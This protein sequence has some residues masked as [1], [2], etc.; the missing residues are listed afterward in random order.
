MDRL[1][2]HAGRTPDKIAVQMAQSQAGR[3]YAQ[4]D[5]D[6]DRLCRDLQA[7]GLVEGQTIAL[8]LANH[9]RALECWWGARRA[10]LYYVPLS[11]K[12]TAQEIAYILANCD[13]Q[14]IIAD[15]ANA[16]LARRSAGLHAVNVGIAIVEPASDVEMFLPTSARE[17]AAYV[18]RPSL[19]GRE[20][21]YS[22]G[23][24]GRPKGI[25]RPLV[26]VD[27]ASELPALEQRM[28]QLFEIDNTTIYLS[29]SPLYHATGRFLNRVVEEGGTAVILPKFDAEAA[30][31]AIE[32]HKVTNT[33]WV[34]TMFSRLLALSTE[35]R[36]R[37][38]LSSHKIALHA[39]APCPLAVKY[40]MIK[41][42][43]PIVHEYYGGSENAGV[44][45]IRAEDWLARPGSVGKSI[46][47][48]LHILDND[49]GELPVGEL[50]LISFDGGVPFTYL[51]AEEAVGPA[52]IRHATYGD[53]GWVDCD[54]YL[55]VSD[56]R[57]DLIISGGVNVYPKEV[58]DVLA[59]HSAVEEVAVIGISD[60]EFGQRVEAVIKLKKDMCADTESII[61][62]CCDKLSSIKCPRSVNFVE[63]LPR[64]ENGKILKRV[65]RE[66]Y[67]R[68]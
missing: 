29:V 9:C 36:A 2:Q 22:S 31:H 24:T 15:P 35:A 28:R 46:S 26:T 4:L 14:L 17:L 20:L 44:T 47:G 23:T 13:A 25:K 50:G 63:E 58:E 45:F 32:R 40:E 56:R 39:A 67:D 7:L 10:G 6:A 30:L 43:G 53:L 68:S 34:P 66:L 27:K 11:T 51:G 57:N 55:F 61:E 1:S 33:Q 59:E 3:T 41:W 52:K 38:D 21:I 18:V 8:L 54:G 48:E 60:A 64:N 16:D 49:G 5:A 19:I 62:F 42:W 65:L 37:Y 12:S